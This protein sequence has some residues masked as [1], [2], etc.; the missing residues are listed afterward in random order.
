MDRLPDELLLMVLERL[1]G[2]A[3]ATARM[4]SRRWQASSTSSSSSPSAPSSSSP[5][6]PSSRWCGLADDPLLRARFYLAPDPSLASEQ[7]MELVAARPSL[8]SVTLQVII[9]LTF[10]FSF[11][12]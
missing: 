1:P 7:V 4:V 6:S 9:I 5:S 2:A 3:L 11:S 8:L 12:F 10:L